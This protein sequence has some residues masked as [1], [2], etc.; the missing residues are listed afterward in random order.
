PS[1]RRRARSL[2]RGGRG[3]AEPAVERSGPG[4]PAPQ[5]GGAA[6]SAAATPQAGAPQAPAPLSADPGPLPAGFPGGPPPAEHGTGYGPAARPGPPQPVRPAPRPVSRP[7]PAPATATPKVGVMGG[8]PLVIGGALIVL[9][10]AAGGYAGVRTVAGQEP[11]STV[12]VATDRVPRVPYPDPLGFSVSVP[13]NWS[14]Y[15]HTAGRDDTVVRFVSPDGTEEFSFRSAESADA[16][17][18]GLTAEAM[19]VDSVVATQTPEQVQGV[20]GAEQTRVRTVEGPQERTS[21]VRVVPGRN[22]GVWVVT[23][24]TPSHRS[25]DTSA[26][27]FDA[28][29]D[30]FRITG[31]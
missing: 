2:L 14:Q 10:G 31:S 26:A 25:E 5:Q 11:S 20:P 7:A 21:W 29:A 18:G 27:L 22:S 12:T 3:T 19:G 13:E 1:A 15:R 4:A 8:I 17:T 23:L 6:A 16:V 9:L 24:T 28:V 30:G